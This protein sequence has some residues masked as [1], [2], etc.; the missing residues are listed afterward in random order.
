MK[1]KDSW[2]AVY[3]PGTFNCVYEYE[4]ECNTIFSDV[5]FTKRWRVIVNLWIILHKTFLRIFIPER[6]RERDWDLFCVS[7]Q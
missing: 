5:S 6:E 7:G 4:V 1:F 2:C 3:Y